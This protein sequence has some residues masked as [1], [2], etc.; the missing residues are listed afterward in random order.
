MQNNNEQYFREVIQK[1]RKLLAKSKD[2]IGLIAVE[3]FNESFQKQGQ[4]MGNGVVKDWPKRGFAPP[5][6]T[7]R[8]LLLKRGTLRRSIKHRKKANGVEIQSNTPYSVLQNDGGEIIVTP[9]M[10]RF[11]WAMYFKHANK[12]TYNIADKSMVDNKRNQ[13]QNAEAEFWI[14][15]A[16][17]KTIT[18]KARPFVYD[19]P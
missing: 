9:K 5:S 19:T 8:F 4:I 10:R 1:Y 7:S 12:L 2:A 3:L 17:A 15:M 13:K 6:Q 14:K 16:M 18:V 11:F